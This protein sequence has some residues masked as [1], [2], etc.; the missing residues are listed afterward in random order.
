ML[1]QSVYQVRKNFGKILF[2]ENSKIKLDIVVPVPETAIP[3]AIG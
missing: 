1:G 3:S 2:Q